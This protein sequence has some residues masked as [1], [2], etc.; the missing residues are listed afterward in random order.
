MASWQRMHGGV[1]RLYP[2][3]TITDKRNNK[4]PV[5][6]MG[7]P[8]QQGAVIATNLCTNPIPVNLT[9][10]SSVRCSLSI[11]EGATGTITDAQASNAAQY[12]QY[13]QAVTAGTPTSLGLEVQTNTGQQLYVL[14]QYFSST[15]SSLGAPATAAG[16]TVANTWTRLTFTVTPPADAATMRIF[17][18][19]Y[20][21]DPRQVGQ[22]IQARRLIVVQDTTVP[23]YFD[24]DFVETDENGYD[25]TGT[26]GSSTSEKT[27][28]I[29]GRD[30]SIKLRYAERWIRSSKA[31][32]PGYQTIDVRRLIIKD[33]LPD[34]TVWSI[35]VFGGE[36]GEDRWEIIAPPQF[37]RG[38]R[39]TRHWSVDVKR[40]PDSLNG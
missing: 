30:P 11:T 27:G 25:W 15:G 22:T 12:I 36:D 4:V 17:V 26:P 3:K 16:P 33:T 18:A 28:I 32:V 21:S 19:I 10:W 24:G 5:P 2:K 23:E 40:R 1:L 38:T 9:N 7:D 31:E 14:A 34:P 37:H 6:D 29:P 20:G 13:T 35:I 8:P 39:H